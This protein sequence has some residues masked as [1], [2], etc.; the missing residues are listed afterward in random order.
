M[1]LGSVADVEMMGLPSPKARAREILWSGTRMPAVFR[2]VSM[3]LG[4]I[5]DPGSTKV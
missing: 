4:T 1:P 5:L 2:L 3:I